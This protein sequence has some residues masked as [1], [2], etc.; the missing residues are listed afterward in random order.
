VWKEKV[1][2]LFAW[3]FAG[4]GVERSLTL[5]NDKYGRAYD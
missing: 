3:L 2:T 4:A 5:R 1:V